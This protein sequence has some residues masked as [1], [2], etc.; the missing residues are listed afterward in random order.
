[1]WKK[2]YNVSLLRESQDSSNDNYTQTTLNPRLDLVQ[3]E[4]LYNAEAEIR[5]LKSIIARTPN[6][7]DDL[8]SE[9]VHVCIL[10]ER[11]NIADRLADALAKHIKEATSGWG[12]CLDDDVEPI[13]MEYLEAKCSP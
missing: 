11:L 10:K 7:N 2:F 12:P 9:F 6:E 4:E 5:K 13:L 1:M 3:A 8:G